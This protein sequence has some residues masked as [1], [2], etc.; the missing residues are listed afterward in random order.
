MATIDLKKVTVQLRDGAANTLDIKIG[1]GN[2]SWTE[3]RP[4][5]YI[6]DRGLISEVRDGDQ[7]PIDV[8]LDASWEKISGSGAYVT[9]T[10]FLKQ[11]NGAAAFVSS[12]PDACRPYAVDI[13]LIYEPDCGQGED[14]IIPDFRYE[15][16]AFD[17]KAGTISFTGKSNAIE[18]ASTLTGV[19]S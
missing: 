19:A 16:I 2:I 15:D 17:P 6:L 4:R 11:K 14:T 13:A 7:T 12:D 8:R 3:H 9:P 5:Q 10:D 1:E 18:A